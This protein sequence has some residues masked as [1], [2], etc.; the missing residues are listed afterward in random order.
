MDDPQLRRHLGLCVLSDDCRRVGSIWRRGQRDSRR[1]GARHV[2][3]L[4]F[5]GGNDVALSAFDKHT[6]REVWRHVLPRQATATPMT[7]LA[8]DGRQM[9]VIA[10]GRGENTSLVAFALPR[11]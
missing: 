1:Y 4:V 3:G 7:Y 2:G 11:M 9:I 10:T 6:G 5:V 8:P